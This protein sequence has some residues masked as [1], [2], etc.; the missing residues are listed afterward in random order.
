MGKTAVKK[1]DKVS[2]T[3]ETCD[4]ALPKETKLRKRLSSQ[5]HTQSGRVLHKE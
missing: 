5:D 3:I 2:E 1:R 4:T